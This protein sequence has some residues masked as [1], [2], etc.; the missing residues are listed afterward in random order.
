MYAD[1]EVSGIITRQRHDATAHR[2][3]RLYASP[4]GLPSK[5]ST[6]HRVAINSITFTRCRPAVSAVWD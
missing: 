4:R 3:Y 1:T 2:R 5:Y 6:V